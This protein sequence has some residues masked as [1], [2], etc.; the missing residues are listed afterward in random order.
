MGWHQVQGQGH[1][2]GTPGRGLRGHMVVCSVAEKGGYVGQGG[3][4]AWARE[5]GRPNAPTF[6]ALCAGPHVV[7]TSS[8]KVRQRRHIMVTVKQSNCQRKAKKTSFGCASR[9][10]GDVGHGEQRSAEARACTCTC[11]CTWTWTWTC[12]PLRQD[13]VP[14]GNGMACILT[15]CIA[16]VR[17]VAATRVCVPRLP[18]S[19]WRICH[20]VPSTA[21]GA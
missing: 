15:G 10:A 1:A 21:T 14:F 2:R 3:G 16:H 6:L 19:Y 4:G 17:S 7:L 18:V 8:A 12:Q 13:Q 9:C 11:T 20:R 5:L